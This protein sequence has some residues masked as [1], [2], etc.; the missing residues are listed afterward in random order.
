M[1]TFSVTVDSGADLDADRHE[2]WARLIDPDTLVR[3]TPGL[4]R[5]QA[6]GDTWVW[7]LEKIG[8]MGI[9][10]SPSF[11]EAMVFEPETSI[12]FTHCPPDGES[13]RIGAAGRYELADTPTGVRVSMTLTITADLPLPESAG[14]MVRELMQ[15]KLTELGD[16]FGANLLADLPP[17]AAS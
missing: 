1:S 2:V 9:H 4:A 7:H 14:E 16:G 3:L 5:I 11:T 17:R 12:A 6:D 8:A 13:E 15:D 10:L